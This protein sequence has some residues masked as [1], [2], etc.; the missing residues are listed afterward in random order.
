MKTLYLHIGPPKTGTSALQAFFAENYRVL[1]RKGVL[2]PKTGRAKTGRA[3]LAG[4]HYMINSITQYQH[5]R[6]RPKKTFTEYVI[7]LKKESRNFQRVLLSSEFMYFDI[8]SNDLVCLKEIFSRIFIIAY[9]RRQTEH[10]KS[11]YNEQVKTGHD[12]ILTIQEYV[13]HYAKLRWFQTLLNYGDLFGKENIIVHPYEKQQFQGG[14]I[15]SDFLRILGLDFDDTYVLPQEEVN[16]SLL[17]DDL[18]YKRMINMLNLEKK[19]TKSFM[20]PLIMHSSSKRGTEKVFLRNQDFLSPQEHLDIIERFAET[21]ATIAREYLGRADGQLFYDPLPDPDEP[22][23][24]YPGLSEEKVVEIT[25]FITDHSSHNIP[26]L[27][28]GIIKGLSSDD[29]KVKEA[30]KILSPALPELNEKYGIKNLI[31]KSLHS[32]IEFLRYKRNYFARVLGVAR[33]GLKN[34]LH[35][36]HNKKG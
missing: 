3:K 7:D 5:E 27:K 35:M 22:W 26:V 28:D 33:K 34:K 21:N 6:Y 24:P 15:F 12:R 9:I 16:Q 17:M 31:P 8:D 2:Y 13:K 14:T 18:E 10:M 30:A 25:R 4:H 32:K 36:I 20:A 19:Q 29:K 1:K 11:N 23:E